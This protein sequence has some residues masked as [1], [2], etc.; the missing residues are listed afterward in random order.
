MTRPLVH[1][2]FH[3]SGAGSL[4]QALEM[5]GRSD[6]VVAHFDDYSVGPIDTL[7]VAARV[8]WLAT[9]VDEPWTEELLQTEAG[10]LSTYDPAC[11]PVVWFSRRDIRSYV[12]FLAWLSRAG[13]RDFAVVDITDMDIAGHRYL[14]P[15]VIPDPLICETALWDRRHILPAVEVAAY[16]R[17]WDRLRQ[18]NAPIRMLTPDGIVSG[19]LAL[20]DSLLMPFLTADWQKLTWVIQDAILLPGNDER[21][22]FVDEFALWYRLD[23]LVEQGVLE[24][25]L[26]NIYTAQ[27]RLA[28]S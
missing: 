25:D 18:E 15:S 6:R 27:V 10:I 16:R 23:Q 7:D 9:R 20:L 21:Y 4:R 3:P 5:A 26:R 1:V 8:E 22:P 11:L 19:G 2:M 12:G 17:D 28:R 13:E 24:G 14:S